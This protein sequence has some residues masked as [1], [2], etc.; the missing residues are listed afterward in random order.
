M[1]KKKLVDL[2]NENKLMREKIIV[3]KR[4]IILKR[5]AYMMNMVILKVISDL[6]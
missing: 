5:K 2:E 4:I 6:L 1:L 3:S